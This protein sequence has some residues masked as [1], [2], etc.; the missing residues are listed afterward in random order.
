MNASTI[1]RAVAAGSLLLVAGGLLPMAIAAPAQAKSCK[2][3]QVS[4]D[5]ATGV[6]VARC[7]GGNR[8]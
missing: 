4:Y 6:G 1:K 8:P 7:L 3:V 2:W 5:P